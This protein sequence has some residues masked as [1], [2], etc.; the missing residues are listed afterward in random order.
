MIPLSINRATV[1]L[2]F[3]IFCPFCSKFNLNYCVIFP[4]FFGW[5]DDEAKKLIWVLYFSSMIIRTVLMM[6]IKRF[7]LYFEVIKCIICQIY[8]DWCC[9]SSITAVIFNEYKF[10]FFF[11]ECLIVKCK[12]NVIQSM[13]VSMK[14]KKKV[15][16][17]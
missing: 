13:T 14:T 9:L 8:Y 7:L 12:R 6:E 11:C 3:F 1:L 16:K 4:S 2:P 5:M 15:I 10:C 17:K